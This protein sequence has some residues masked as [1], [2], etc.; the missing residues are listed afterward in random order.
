METLNLRTSIL[1]I[2]TELTT[3]QVVNTNASWI[4]E[5]LVELGFDVVLHETVPDNST[6]MLEALNRCAF[7]SAHIFVCGGLGPTTDD[8]TRDVVS[9][10]LERFLDFHQ[11]SWDQ[12]VARLEGYGIPVVESQKQQ[13]YFPRGS[14]VLT[15]SAG[16][17]NA[18]MSE[19]KTKTGV[20]RAWVLPGP[21][22]EIE[23]VWNTHMPPL[24]APLAP[25][26]KATEL[27]TW[28]CAGLGEAELGE[29]TERALAGSGYATG[30]RASFP[31]I[32]IKV[33][34]PAGTSQQVPM[35][36]PLERLETA[37]APWVVTKQ[38]GDIAKM[39]VEQL[40]AFET[41]VSLFDGATGGALAARLG[42]TIRK[43]DMVSQL[44]KTLTVSTAWNPFE[45]PA[46]AITQ[47][48]KK[49]GNTPGLFMAVT[50]FTSDLKWA[51]G[52]SGQ[53]A[54]RTFEKIETLDLHYKPKQ[55]LQHPTLEGS[56]TPAA[57]N[58]RS[59]LRDRAGA[60][61]VELALKQWNRWLSEQG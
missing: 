32:E 34:A 5:R 30:Y 44:T 42:T 11:P 50:G 36:A 7:T 25:A 51:I 54:N 18:F 2:G 38:G 61:V 22:R 10:W 31:Y 59:T 26:R 28:R 52:L 4:S 35:A 13:C 49:R 16:T 12:I 60:L 1:C 6:L 48:I 17:A 53:L 19:K 20:V 37:I 33:W 39:L 24:L 41:R 14:H 8:F 57:S 3:G 45:D 58:Y 55:G 21:P 9:K 47:A 56:P 46:A 23:S 43:L 27:L 40:S 15:N 29:I